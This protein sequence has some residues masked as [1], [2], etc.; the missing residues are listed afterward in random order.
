MRFEWSWLIEV[1]GN[2]T[3]IALGQVHRLV[4]LVWM[5]Q[6]DGDCDYGAVK[7]V[8]LYRAM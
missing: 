4:W 8:D 3:V 2:R 1:D 6:V 7:V 5:E